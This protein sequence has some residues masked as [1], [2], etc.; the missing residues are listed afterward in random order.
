MNSYTFIQEG[1]KKSKNTT[2]QNGGLNLKSPNMDNGEPFH[3]QW[4]SKN[5]KGQMNGGSANKK[6]KSLSKKGGSNECSNNDR[7]VYDSQGIIGCNQPFGEPSQGGRSYI[8][9][10]N[11]YSC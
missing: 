1:G 11:V 2:A 10:K 5:D 8:Y 3:P 7:L 9:P 6:K 4:S